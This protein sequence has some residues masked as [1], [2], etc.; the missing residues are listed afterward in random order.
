MLDVMMNPYLNV[1]ILD[2][3]LDVCSFLGPLAVFDVASNF[4]ER[5]SKIF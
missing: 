3:F 5:S 1:L 2:H 4:S